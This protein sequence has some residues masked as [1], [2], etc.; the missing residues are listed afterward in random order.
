MPVSRSGGRSDVDKIKDPSSTLASAYIPTDIK[1][2]FKLAE[3]VYKSNILILRALYKL[4]EYPITPLRFS[5]ITESMD[6]EEPDDDLRLNGEQ[7]EELYRKLYEDHLDINSTLINLNLNYYLYSNDFPMVYL[8]FSRMALCNECHKKA[9]AKIEKGDPERSKKL[10]SLRSA[11]EVPLE[12]LREVKWVKN[13]F[14]AKCPRCKKEQIFSTVDVPDRAN[15]AGVSISGL[16][17]FR[18]EIQELEFSKA[19]RYLYTVSDMTKKKVKANDLF[20]LSREPMVVLKAVSEDKKV[21]Y[22]SDAV[23]HF[24]MPTP[25]FENDSPWSWPLLVS[26]FQIVFFINTLRRGAEAIAQEHITPKPYMA[27]AKEIDSLLAKIDM[28]DVRNMLEEA[29]EAAQKDDNRMAILPV[30]VNTGIL[31]QQGRAFMPQA[32]ISQA[33]KDMLTGLGIAEGLLSGQ[34][35][36][37]ANS[38]AVRILENGFLSQRDMIER[39][40]QYLNKNLKQHFNLP[41][42]EVSLSEFRKL[43][44]S[45]H[46][47][48]LGEAVASKYISI[49][50]YVKELGYEPEDEREQVKNEILAETKHQAEMEGVLETKRA[51]IMAKADAARAAANTELML[52]EMQ[53]MID[54]TVTAIE[55]LMSKGYDRQWAMQYVNNYMGQQKAIA[56]KEAA[57]AQAA[58]T[59][60]ALM[61]DRMANATRGLNRAESKMQMHQDIQAASL[62]PTMEAV[63]QEQGILGQTYQKLLLMNEVDRQSYLDELEPRNPIMHQQ[64][65]GM[66]SSSPP[67]GAQ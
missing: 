2:A 17:L 18:L 20:T 33:T 46:K 57:I 7:V 1:K 38:I 21:E 55:D 10:K 50:T 9:K 5:A 56:D 43:D 41:P 51:Q 6:G 40:L 60:E 64:L 11:L 34:G 31:N 8:P 3:R 65:L 45:L 14:K 22:F 42:C 58:Q 35:P 61:R 39:F 44:D 36:F 29:Y 32:E 62:D 59:Q 19:R 16:N 23:F 26:A 37:A 30:P 67:G 15:H 13:K 54:S 63:S 25:T 28:A 52:D 53:K 12:D 49:K 48:R 66:L 47:Q 4:A 27:P 24:K